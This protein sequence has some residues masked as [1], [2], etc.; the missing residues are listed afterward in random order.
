MPLSPA[1]LV[2]VHETVDLRILRVDIE[3]VHSWSSDS[4][5]PPILPPQLTGIH[6]VLAPAE[7]VVALGGA[8]GVGEAG[9]LAVHTGAVSRAPA[10]DRGSG[11]TQQGVRR[12]TAGGAWC[13]PLLAAVVLCVPVSS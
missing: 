4:V 1:A 8:L 9:A 6:T 2:P 5:T 7:V 11:D 3:R 12:Y 10:G 13:S